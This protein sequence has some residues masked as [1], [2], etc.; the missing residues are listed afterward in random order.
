[1]STHQPNVLL[2]DVTEHNWRDV[3]GISAY[4]EQSQ[5]VA[6]TAYYLCLATY[7]GDWQSLAIELNGV[8]VGHVM[9]A[10]DAEDNSVWLGGLVVD[11]SHQGAGV[12]R[13]AVEAFIDRFSQDGHT[14]IALSYSM[15]NTRAAALYAKV[16]FVLTGE[17]EGDEVVARLQV[18]SDET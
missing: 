1:M 15:G 7:G 4:P 3:A 9:W 11:A 16:G 10:R 8:V 5:F 14:N 17:V 13:A 2:I 6:S 18:G 12:G